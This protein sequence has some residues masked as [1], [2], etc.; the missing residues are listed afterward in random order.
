MINKE[1][2]NIQLLE[3]ELSKNLTLQQFKGS[4]LYDC[5]SSKLPNQATFLL[6][7]IEIE[8]H[9]YVFTLYFNN[10][11]ILFFVQFRTVPDTKSLTWKSFDSAKEFD[12][13]RLHKLLLEKDLGGNYK[14]INGRIEYNFPWG[15]I[16]SAQ[17]PHTSVAQV[18]IRYQQ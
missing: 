17:N 15:Q 18:S 16:S 3:V 2:G 7:P 12:C 1:T 10:E 14:S 5:V 13:L 6:R 11:N 8:G 4:K 9:Y